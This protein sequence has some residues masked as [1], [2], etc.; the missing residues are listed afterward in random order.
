MR[1]PAPYG[2]YGFLLALQRTSEG[3]LEPSHHALASVCFTAT[4]APSF[5]L[6]A[7]H[8]HPWGMRLREGREAPD[9]PETWRLGPPR[10]KEQMFPGT[11]RSNRPEQNDIVSHGRA[12]DGNALQICKGGTLDA[13]KAH[14]FRGD[15]PPLRCAPFSSMARRL[16]LHGSHWSTMRKRH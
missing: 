14:G 1:A 2:P 5:A 12:C 3:S 7:P 6:V 4:M 10:P 13:S 8:L 16:G 9:R 11:F 15:A